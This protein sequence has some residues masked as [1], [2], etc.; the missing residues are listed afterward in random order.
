MDGEMLRVLQPTRESL[1]NSEDQISDQLTPHLYSARARAGKEYSYHV[2]VL[3]LLGEF[4]AR[5]P[6][7][8]NLSLIAACV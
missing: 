8:N 7:C 2:V 3:L 4:I 5:M 6:L 1:G